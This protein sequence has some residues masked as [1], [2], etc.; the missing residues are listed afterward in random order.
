FHR[1]HDD[2]DREL[3]FKESLVA[4]YRPGDLALQDAGKLRWADLAGKPILTLPHG[5]TFRDLAEAGFAAAGLA[6]EPAM[7]ATYVG[8]LLGLVRAGLGIAIVPGYATALGDRTHMRWQR[9]ER[10]VIERE[11]VMVSRSGIALSP[12]ATALAE[13]LKAAVRGKT[14]ARPARR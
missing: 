6:L 12:A 2:L 1:T 11:V 9:L 4:V 8:T 10:P 3:L 14:P 5:S 13:H 7:E